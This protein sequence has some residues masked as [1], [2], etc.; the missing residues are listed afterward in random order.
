VNDL[1]ERVAN[2][3]NGLSQLLPQYLFETK[4]CFLLAYY[5]NGS[6]TNIYFDRRKK[7]TLK[8]GSK[9]GIP[10]DYDGGQDFFPQAQYDSLLVAFCN[11]FDLTEQLAEQK[12]IVLKGPPST[13]QSFKRMYQKLDPEDNP[14]L[15]IVKTKQ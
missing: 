6:R 10:N 1:R 9:T 5:L 2:P 11:A 3:L 13:V 14:V 4:D 12:K 15:I 8:F 7:R